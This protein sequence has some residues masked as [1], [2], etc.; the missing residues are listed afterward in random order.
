MR[1]VHDD[2]AYAEVRRE[3]EAKIKSLQQQYGVTDPRAEAPSSKMRRE[4][5]A[6]AAATQKAGGR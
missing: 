3:L 6:R 5:R 4:R 1:S 2:P